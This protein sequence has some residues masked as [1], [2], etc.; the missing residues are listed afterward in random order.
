MKLKR[1]FI[2]TLIFTSSPI[3]AM[4]SGQKYLKNQL[5]KLLTPK[6]PEND[7]NYA[8]LFLAESG[9]IELA[10]NCFR[11][12]VNVNDHDQANWTN[13]TPLT[14]ASENDHIKIVKLL[15]EHGAHVDGVKNNGNTALTLASRLGYATIVNILLKHNADITIRDE[16]DS[17]PLKYVTK[18]DRFAIA[19]LLLKHINHLLDQTVNPEICHKWDLYILDALN[20]IKISQMFDHIETINAFRLILCHADKLPLSIKKFYSLSAKE[21]GKRRTGEE[22]FKETIKHLRTHAF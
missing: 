12:G 8:L 19:E 18:W 13:L 4:I 5:E 6:R 11:D 14:C 1:L 16:Y 10:E 21:L 17:S 9:D 15:I 20:G 7:H 3:C 22:A 2:L